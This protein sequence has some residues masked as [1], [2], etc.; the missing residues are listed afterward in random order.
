MQR[1]AKPGLHPRPQQRHRAP[2]GGR[3]D[4]HAQPGDQRT[5]QR[6]Q[7]QH[8]AR[9]G[10]H[11][12]QDGQ[13]A[14]ALVQAGGNHRHQ[15]GQA[16][17]RHQR[18]HR[19]QAALA[20]RHHVPQLVQ[21]HA[22]QD[23]EQRLAAEGRNIALHRKHRG[24]RFQAHQRGGDGVRGQ[25]GGGG[26]GRAD[27]LA[28]Q[29]HAGGP[30]QVH[31]CHALQADVHAAVHGRAGGRQDADHGERFVG[32]VVGFHRAIAM[33]QHDG[34]TEP[35]AQRLRHLGADHR[36]EH[37]V[38]ALALGQHQRLAVAVAEVLEVAGA[39]AQHGKTA[40]AVT[41]RQRH[42]PGDSAVA[43]QHLDTAVADAVAG[44]AD[45]EHRVQQQLDRPGARADDQVGA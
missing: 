1:D 33:R 10:A 9:S 24:A 3:A 35:V 4:Q 31:R 18:A 19:L 11:G 28:G 43:G 42:D 2:A 41:Q 12:A 21:R 45:A 8:L 13:L 39:G 16:D 14:A 44:I 27:R 25:V 34:L 40:V 17:H 30:V 29:R 6:Q 7:Q 32:M 37:A 5:L 26:L 36:V 23:G 20:Q 15:R 22:G 38:K